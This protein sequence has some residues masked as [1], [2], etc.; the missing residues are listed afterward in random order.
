MTASL[1]DE[2]EL[3]T[4]KRQDAPP[5]LVALLASKCLIRKRVP[6]PVI[7]CSTRTP[8]RAWRIPQ[9]QT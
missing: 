6:E 8:K 5:Q 2:L 7:T 1:F 3:P 9:A 4:Y